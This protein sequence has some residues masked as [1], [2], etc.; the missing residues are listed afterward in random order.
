MSK[1]LSVDVSTSLKCHYEYLS[2]QEEPHKLEFRGTIARGDTLVDAVDQLNLYLGLL[3]PYSDSMQFRA[4]DRSSNPADDLTGRIKGR[5]EVL[6]LSTIKSRFWVVECSCGNR[7]YRKA[8]ALKNPLNVNDRCK[9][10][11]EKEDE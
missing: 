10:C 6:G 5:L 3:S 8:K 9:A 7:E 2:G 1:T 11:K 4:F